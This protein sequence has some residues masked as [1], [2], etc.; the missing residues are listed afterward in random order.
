[1][2]EIKIKAIPPLI[3]DTL[4]FDLREAPIPLKCA[5][6]K[7]WLGYTTEKI[8]G[9]CFKCTYITTEY[10]GIECFICL[11]HVGEH[12]VNLPFDFVC[13]N[14][15]L[16]SEFIEVDEFKK[17]NKKIEDEARNKDF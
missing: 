10:N 15:V 14:C 16:S 4:W 6:C 5:D 3:E 9:L 8:T 12:N 11:K 1:M 7:K 13:I 2:R 17:R